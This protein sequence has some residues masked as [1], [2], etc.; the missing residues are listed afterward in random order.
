MNALMKY[1]YLYELD[2]SLKSNYNKLILSKENK[3]RDIEEDFMNV[4]N[5]G[6]ITTVFQP[7]ISLRDGS[8]LGFESLSRGPKGS[9][10]ESPN[11]LF[12]L[13]KVYN[14]LWELEFLCRIKALENYSKNDMNTKLFINVDPSVI[15]NDKFKKGFT[16][17]FLN[18]FNINPENIIFEITERNSVNDFT[19]FKKTIDNY[20]DQG[21]KIAIDDTGSGYSGLKLITEIHPHYLK[22]D[23]NL[24]KNIDKDGLKHALIKTFADFCQVTDIKLIAEGIENENELNTLINLGIHYGQGFYIQKPSPV[25]QDIREDLINHIALINDRKRSF[26]HSK[27][28]SVCIGD[29]SKKSITLSA[30]DTGSKA[31][32]IFNSNPTIYGLPVIDGNHLCGLVM[33]DRFYSKLGTQYGFA[34]YLNRPIT[35]VMDNNPLSVDYDTDL[36]VVSRLAMTRS[37]EYLYDYIVVTHNDNFYGIVSIKDL[38]VSSTELK[39][40]YAKHL[41]PLSG[42]PGN[43]LIEQ[44]LNEV[45]TE[46]DYTVLYIDI[47]NFKVYNDVYG[48]ENGDKVLQ[49][50]SKLLGESLEKYNNTSFIGHIGGDDFII[51]LK[52]NYS[53][54]ECICQDILSAFENS[55]KHFYTEE[56]MTTKLIISKN[57]H[58]VEE[59]YSL[60]TLSIA[61]VNCKN[62]CFANI[63]ELS[64]YSSKIKKKCKEIW[65]NCY[66]IE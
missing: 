49:S 28:T 34:L 44:K 26:Y 15:N 46:N 5:E 31:L 35:L 11:N 65:N 63:Y 6:L 55:L 30:N 41:N 22:L 47:D 29:I 51:V 3:D 16:K 62:K 4:L 21:Y 14:K 48:F 7:I 10:M 23:M 12:D 33:R 56:H 39:V 1:K 58:G 13:A 60:L 53:N 24:I 2:E 45:I 52:N 32:D 19:S 38:L 54:T 18:N 50:L 37:D 36:E 9:L 57:R 20:K 59:Q 64:E 8:I 40:N 17:D 25:I 27:T 42:L 43:V 61:G 66:I